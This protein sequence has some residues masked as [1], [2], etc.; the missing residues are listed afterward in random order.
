M[1]MAPDAERPVRRA[2]RSGSRLAG[3]CKRAYSLPV[4]RSF[5]I[6][7]NALGSLPLLKQN[8]PS[9]PICHFSFP[10][11]L[12]LYPDDL[13]SMIPKARHTPPHIAVNLELY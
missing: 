4:A 11:P 12:L 13:F 8:Q 5:Q 1:G 9:H 3:G 2:G 10:T 6:L 7:S